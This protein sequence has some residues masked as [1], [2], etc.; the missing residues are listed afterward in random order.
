MSHYYSGSLYEPR[1]LINSLG[2]VLLARTLRCQWLIRIRITVQS[3]TTAIG[4]LAAWIFLTAFAAIARVAIETSMAIALPR[5]LST[6]YGPIHYALRIITVLSWL[7]MVCSSWQITAEWC[8]LLLAT[9]LRVSLHKA[10]FT[11]RRLFLASWIVLLLLLV[12]NL[13][14]RAGNLRTVLELLLLIVLLFRLL[15]LLVLAMLGR[16]FE[17]VITMLLVQDVLRF[18]LRRVRVGVVSVGAL[19]NNEVSVRTLN[20]FLPFCPYLFILNLRGTS[21]NSFH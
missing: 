7:V 10:T 5:C 1:N 14:T 8:L 13:I 6:G 19:L 3:R 20:Y 18:V 9:T 4:L 16:L 21:L 11:W 2:L 15:M 12:L 17:V